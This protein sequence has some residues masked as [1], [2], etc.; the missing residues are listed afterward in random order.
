MR[1]C[2]AVLVVGLAAMCALAGPA[3][4]A[5]LAV[6]GTYATIQAA[7]D[8]A[9]T[10]DTIR[11]GAGTYAEDVYVSTAGITI[12]GAGRDLTTIDY[13]GQPGHNNAGMYVTASDVTLEG[14]TLTR[15]GTASVPRYGLKVAAVAGVTVT[16]VAVTKA[17]RTGLDVLGATD[18]SAHGVVLADNGGHGMQLC[19]VVGADIIDLTVSGSAWNDVSVATWGRYTA[20]GTGDIVFAGANSFGGNATVNGGL[21]LEAGNYSV[22]S[23]PELITW[24]TVLADGADV[25][26]QPADF[27]YALGGP[28][29]VEG[30]FT[31]VYTRFYETLDQAKFAAAGAPA[32]V[33]A[34][35]R[36]IQDADGYGD[37]TTFYVFDLA[38]D[39]MGIQAAIDAAAPGDTILVAAG[40]YTEQVVV[41]KS[42]TL[43]GATAGVNKNGYA[44]PA[45]YAWDPGVESI[46]NHPNP[47]VA[48]LAV[49]DIRNTND[50]VFDGFVV[51]ELNAVKSL[52][53][54]LVR[55]YAETQAVDNIVVRNSVI[56]PNTDADGQDGTH[57]RMGLY[58]A[59]PSYSP[60]GITNSTFAG[61]T[62][63]GALGNGNNVFVWGSAATYGPVRGD[64]T[65]TVIEDNDIYGS[66]RSGIEIAGSADHLAIRDNRIH[67]NAGLATDDPTLLNYGNGIAVIRMGGD[68][69]RSDAEGPVGLEI[70]GNKIYDNEKN[71]IYLGPFNSG[72]LIAG[73]CFRD[74]GWDGLVVDLL[75]SYYG[76]NPQYG[77]TSAIAATGNSFLGNGGSGAA[78]LG[79][80]TNGF[81]LDA[82]QSWWGAADGPSGEGPGTG[83]AVTA[84]VAFAPWQQFVVADAPQ[85]AADMVLTATLS[86]PAA[87]LL[88]GGDVEFFVDST[89]AGTAPMG[90]DGSAVLALGSYPVGVYQVYAQVGCLRSEAV[91]VAVYDPSA[92]FVTG[93]GWFDSPAGAYYPEVFT[94]GTFFNDTFDRDPP[95]ASTQTPG[96]WYPDRYAPAGFLSEVF[97]GEGRLKV[98]IAAADYLPNGST[99]YNYQGRKFDLGNGLNT[100]ISADLFV[101]AD[102]EGQSRHASMWATVFD[103]AGDISG[104]PIMGFTAGTGFRI[105]TQDTDG[106]SAN[107]YQAGWHAVTYPADF[108]YGA[109]YSLRAELG[110]DEYRYYINDELVWSDTATFGSVVWGNMMLQAYNY[111]A[112]Y[113]VYWDNVGAGPLYAI[114]TGKATFGFVSKY[115]KGASIPEGNTQFMF[116]A[117]DL[118]FH[119]TSYDWLVVTGSSFAKYKGEGTVNGSP[120][121]TGGPYRFQIW[122][123][124]G[125]KTGDDTFRIRIWYE[126]AGAEMVVYDNGMN[127]AIGGGSIVVHTN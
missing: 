3:L 46:I 60:Y 88:V 40:V 99:F 94:T 112:D 81:L 18:F 89:S 93:G 120:S 83:D 55:V 34:H 111:G 13:A 123:G 127:Q 23:N 57:G 74:N 41:E 121:P 11:V 49:V 72:H 107:G 114:P 4:A 66:H 19:D 39:T 44:V 61:N 48:Y 59:A 79:M 95:L 9:V 117:G 96:A 63:F 91:L 43:L 84:N 17:Y 21:Q 52:N 30:G 105:F 22:P 67:D 33:P 35:D 126:S 122:A 80:P 16:N 68:K 47:T 97:D 45:G 100:Y 70:T 82:A 125:G 56:G 98:S 87:M 116:K 92:G 1:K 24:S 86:N 124:D 5:D 32:H 108:A 53:T 62:I 51:Q 28:E 109:W 14:F 29:A 69:T 2:L 38:G 6:P 64:F 31:Y 115:K 102:W 54:S 20:L 106:D 65:G 78:V 90:S 73:N 36:F 119:S 75:E 101:G 50:V 12:V 71:G 10:G 37:A 15:S 104:Y 76:V 26:V 42:L 8:A 77:V 27:G 113:D 118:N 25:T 110:A 58:L 85:P 103:A 7:V